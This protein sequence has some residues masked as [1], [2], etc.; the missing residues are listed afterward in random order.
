MGWRNPFP[1]NR[2]LGSLKVLKISSLGCRAEFRTWRG[3]QRADALP[4]ELRR[5]LTELRRTLAE[6]RRTLLRYV[7]PRLIYA[8]PLLSYTAP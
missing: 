2:F 8:A 4:T 7:A 6:Q 3:L 1:W 5:T